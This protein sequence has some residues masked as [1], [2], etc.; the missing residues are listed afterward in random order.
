MHKAR[1]FFYVCAGLF[2]LALSYHL[3]ARSAG[4][5]Q[6]STPN[7]DGRVERASGRRGA[8]VSVLPMSGSRWLST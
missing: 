3:G 8:A 6:G 5:Q 7:A 4:A 1:A 2:L